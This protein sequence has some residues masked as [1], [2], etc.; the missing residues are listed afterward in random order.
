MCPLEC[1]TQAQ[2]KNV[3]PTNKKIVTSSCQSLGILKRYLAVA[4]QERMP[5]A[6]AIAIVL[7]STIILLRTAIKESRA[8]SMW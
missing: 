2:D 7:S 5:P 6:I 3:A 1:W 8:L 4:S